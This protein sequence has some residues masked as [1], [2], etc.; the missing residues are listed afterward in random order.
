MKGFLWN[1]PGRDVQAGNTRRLASG[2]RIGLWSLVL[3]IL[4]FAIPAIAAETGT[5][6]ILQNPTNSSPRIVS[7]WGGGGSEQIVMKSD[8][9]VWDWGANSEGELGNGTT[10]DADLPLQ[11]LG[12][13]GVGYLAPVAAIQGGELHNTALKANGTVWAWGGNKYGQLGDGSTNWGTPASLSTTPV[14]VHDLTN[15]RSLGGRGYHTLALKTDGTVWA[16]GRND[17]GELG[18]GV[19]YDV[20]YMGIGEGTNVPVQVIGLTNPASLSAGGFFSLALMSNGTVMAWGQNNDGQCGNGSNANCLLPVPVLGLT[21]VAAISGGWEATL[22]LLSNG[23]VMAWGLNGNGELGDGTTNNRY[24]PVQVV[25]LS[26]I[27]SVWEGDQNSMALRADGTVWKWGENQYG[28]L[29]NGTYDDG[30]V[31]H[32]TPQ[33]VP[34][35]SNIVVAVCRDYH[36]ICI[37]NN[38]NVWV[39]GDNRYGGCGDFTGNSVLTP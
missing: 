35:L 9:T 2:C 32:A 20:G 26:N 1:S 39:W 29:G 7:M 5:L 27:I 36:N 10:N 33:Q 16:W 30:T 22:A 31:V 3:C 11:V 17:Y 24:S 13:N 28:E 19:A 12:P 38:G 8:G 25:G 6:L 18:I 23:T 4:N 21:N 34:G 15:V 37:Q 14:Q